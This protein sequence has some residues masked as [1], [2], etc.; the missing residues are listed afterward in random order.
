MNIQKASSTLGTERI[1]VEQI[2]QR[3]RVD[4][5]LESENV[6]LVVDI[7]SHDKDHIDC[8]YYFADHAERIIFWIDDFSMNKLT[9]WR[10][11]PGITT[12]T[13]IK[14]RSNIVVR[15][16]RS[17][18]MF[19]VTEVNDVDLV[20]IDKAWGVVIGLVLNTHV[21]RPLMRHAALSR[22]YYFNG[23]SSAR[24]D[25][26][27]SI[28]ATLPGTSSLFCSVLLFNSPLTHIK[29]INK[30]FK[31][32]IL[33]CKG[34]NDFTRSLRSEWQDTV[35]FGTLILN[36]NVGFLAISSGT[37]MLHRL[38]QTLSYISVFFGIGSIMTGMFLSRRYRQEDRDACLSDVAVQTI[39]TSAAITEGVST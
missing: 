23:E 30:M 25:S 4:W 36:A 24:L 21:H 32:D 13:Q 12:A 5:L 1:C 27:N 6:D 19:S 22:F 2:L 37:I 16:L 7:L 8:A 14:R 38:A 10:A 15:E 26:S 20:A 34:W 17:L 28:Y 39:N 33:N 29:N 18:V 31:D 35:L 11:M 3:P 9:A